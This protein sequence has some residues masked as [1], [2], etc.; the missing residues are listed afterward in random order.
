MWATIL[1]IGSR[2]PSVMEAP[3]PMDPGLGMLI[4]DVTI[5]MIKP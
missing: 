5:D 4:G 3:M 2:S 1:I